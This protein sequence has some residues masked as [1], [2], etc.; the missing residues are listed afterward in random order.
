MYTILLIFPTPVTRPSKLVWN[1]PDGV[2]SRER[3]R[4]GEVAAAAAAA[5][6]ILYINQADMQFDPS[7]PS[8]AA[9]LF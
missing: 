4:E 9:R 2:E 6:P 1:L 3:E 5:V 8:F 7:L